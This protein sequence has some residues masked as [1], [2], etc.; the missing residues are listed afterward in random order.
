[1]ISILSHPCLIGLRISKRPW[2]LFGFDAT[3]DEDPSSLTGFKA[4]GV[5]GLSSVTAFGTTA[6]NGGN[7]KLQWVLRKFTVG[8]VEFL[9]P[10]LGLCPRGKIMTLFL[11]IVRISSGRIN[12]RRVCFSLINLATIVS[13]NE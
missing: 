12:G 9:V 13:N 7:G 4:L 6:L 3:T 10:R 1:M 8:E 11:S 5:F 2:R